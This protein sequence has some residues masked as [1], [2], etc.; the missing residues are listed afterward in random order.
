MEQQIQDLIASIRKEGIEEANAEK[1][2]IINEAKEKRDQILKEANEKREKLL[3]DTAKE[4]ELRQKSMEEAIKQAARD[5]SL[6]LKMSIEDEFKNLLSQEVKE[7]MKGALLEKVISSVVKSEVAGSN[8]YLELSDKDFKE[9]E[10]NLSKEFAKEVKNGLEFRVNPQIK[11]GFKVVEKDGSA[12]IDLT[13]DEVTALIYPY[14]SS[15]LK[16][17]L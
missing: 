15:E 3:E 12:F 6:S 2:R 10:A 13:S 9:V 8:V 17:L 11:S 1:E 4:L 14:V 16:K 5:V 7:N